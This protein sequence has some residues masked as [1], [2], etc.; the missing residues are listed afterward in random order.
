MFASTPGWRFAT[1]STSGPSVTREVSAASA[2]SA[3]QHSGTGAGPAAL[4]PRR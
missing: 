2:D 1:F 3:V 4:P